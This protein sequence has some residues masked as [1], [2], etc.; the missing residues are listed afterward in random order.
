METVKK[1]KLIDFFETMVKI[2]IFEITVERNFTMGNIY[3]T[4]HLAIGQ[5]AVAVGSIR[6]IKDSDLIT[7]THRGHA[8]CIAKGADLNIMMAEI[9][10]RAT[11]YCKGKGG[12]MHIADF[13]KGN[14][15]ANGIVGGSIG[16]ATGAALAI[17]KKKSGQI[18]LCFFGDGAVN[19]GIFHES[20]NMAAIWNLPV[21]Y[22]CENNQYGMGTNIKKVIKNKNISDRSRA[23]CIEGLTID[24][25]DVLEIY[26]T[27]TKTAEIVREQCIPYFIECVTYRLRGHSIRDSQR[28]R[29]KDEAK[30]WQKFCPIEKFKKYLLDSNL[31]TEKK[32]KEI[33]NNAGKQVE[34]AV[35]FAL[36]SPLPDISKVTEDIYA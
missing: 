19:Q 31:I 18:I 21:I 36:S 17:K 14:L 24:G 27:I 13:E 30:N 5:E 26:N 2:R 15:G 29:P 8:H 23:Y 25:N 35:K 28:Y 12:S 20:L 9:F 7:S 33:E 34:D 6:A 22:I 32:I 3:G 11:G 1:E 4:A 16:I 10:G